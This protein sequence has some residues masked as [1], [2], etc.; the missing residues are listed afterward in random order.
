MPPVGYLGPVVS[1]L[2]TCLMGCSVRDNA[3]VETVHGTEQVAINEFS[4]TVS[5][6]EKWLAFTEWTL[7]KD[8]VFKDLP[9]SEYFSRIATLNLETGELVRHAL[10]SVA[11]ETLGFSP[12][13]DGW[14]GQAGL[15]VI[16][17]RFRPAGWRGEMFY[18]QQYFQGMHP[19]LHPGKPGLQMLE[20]PLTP[21]ACSDFPPAPNFKFRDRA[22]DLHSNEV[23]AVFIGGTIQCVYYRGERPYRTNMIL[24]LRQGG[25][26]EVV[27]EKETKA[28]TLMS[29]ACVRV[30]PDGRYLS[31]VVHSKR[32]AFLSGPRE[33][34]FVRDLSTGREKEI[35]KYGYMSNL[36]WSP[37]GERLYF[38]SGGYSSDSAVRVVNVAATFSN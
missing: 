26:E 10:T 38:A 6:D 35:A 18:F 2:A 20:H 30:S 37:R 19:A 32:Q 36:I 27:A 16:E 12:D 15:E 31:Y 5:P 23:S 33:T 4:I 13:D 22:W 1:L 17:Q 9:R 29:I 34:L 24:R 28:G 14:V 21:G 25:D 11:A 3:V 7:P 8:R